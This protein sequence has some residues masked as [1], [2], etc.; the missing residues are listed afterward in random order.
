MGQAGGEKGGETS[1]VRLR[2]RVSWPLPCMGATAS[3]VVVMQWHNSHSG[4]DVRELE[5]KA[6]GLGNTA[7]PPWHQLTTGLTSGGMQSPGSGPSRVGTPQKAGA[8]GAFSS[9]ALCR[10]GKQLQSC[11][12]H[13]G[14][15]LPGAFSALS[16]AKVQR[17]NRSP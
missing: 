17:G 7:F 14:L 9:S 16:P 4:A 10:L 12:E 1:C 5:T 8:G 15:P 2:G 13:R 11:R 6:G 3:S